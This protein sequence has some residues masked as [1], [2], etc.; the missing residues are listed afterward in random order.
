MNCK[1]YG[2]SK[3]Y[4]SIYGKMLNRNKAFE[5][6]YDLY[7][8][9]IIVNKVEDCYSA[10][11]VVHSMWQRERGTLMIANYVEPRVL[12]KCIVVLLGD[13]DEKMPAGLSGVYVA[14]INLHVLKCTTP[15]SIDVRRRELRVTW[16]WDAP[17][18]NAIVLIRPD[19]VSYTHLTLPTKA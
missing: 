9:R 10:L 4:F 2:R 19:A 15:L 11:G 6:I 14:V 5:D 3:S 1:I 13:R 16:V 7:A 18:T 12:L 17:L 8:I